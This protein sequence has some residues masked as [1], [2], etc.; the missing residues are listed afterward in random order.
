MQ[1]EQLVIANFEDQ[2]KFIAVSVSTAL[3]QNSL[4][5]V[6][7]QAKIQ[8]SLRPRTR[9][10]HKGRGNGVDDWSSLFDH[11]LT[12]AWIHFYVIM[13]EKHCTQDY[14]MHSRK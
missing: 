5:F 13:D 3:G 10:T 1:K 2:Q 8:G 4:T 6:E 11:R 12:S 9:L 7:L 14:V